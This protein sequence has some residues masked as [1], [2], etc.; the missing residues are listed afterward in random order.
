VDL[1][2]VEGS[3]ELL[4]GEDVGEVDERPE[5]RGDADAV[6]GGGVDVAGAVHVDALEA[7]LGGGCHLARG[8][9]ARDD[10][11]ERC[12][13]AVTQ[14]RVGAAGEHRGDRRG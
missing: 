6:V 10:L 8:G 9:P 11:P 5:R 2:L 13:G 7:M 4:R 12:G 3:R 14:R 1:G